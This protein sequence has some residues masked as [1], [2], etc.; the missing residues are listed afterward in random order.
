MYKM[1][2]KPMINVRLSLRTSPVRMLTVPGAVSA[3]RPQ[4]HRMWYRR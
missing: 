3:L 4:Y 1:N 2:K